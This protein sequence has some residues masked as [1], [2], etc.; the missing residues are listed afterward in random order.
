MSA[1]PTDSGPPDLRAFAEAY[2]AH[3]SDEGRGQGGLDELRD[4]PWLNTGP[5]A[6]QWSVRARTF[7]RFLDSVLRPMEARRAPAPLRILDAGAGNGWLSYRVSLLGH[8]AVAVDVRVDDVDGLGAAGGYGRLLPDMFPRVAASFEELPM[9]A[10]SFDLVVF[11]ASLHYALELSGAL[12]EATRV[13]A[14]GGAVAVLDSPFYRNAGAGEAM[15][16]EKRAAAADLFGERSTVLAARPVVEYLTSERL[17][18]ASRAA[19]LTWRRLR[20]RYPLWYEVRG[21]RAALTGG[22][23]PSRFDLWVGRRP[24]EGGA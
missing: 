2:A 21:L 15:V 22:R 5:V 3:R 20:V 6:R 9:R 24:P 19:G 16:A 10:G 23:A 8:R 12:E 13:L 7:R 4:L 11:N 18:E 14:P 1:A 17:R